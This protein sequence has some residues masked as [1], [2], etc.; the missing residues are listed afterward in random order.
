MTTEEDAPNTDISVE[1]MF[2]F[3]PNLP[4][5]RVNILASEYISI[6]SGKPFQ[7]LLLKQI[8]TEAFED[9]NGT[10][11]HIIYDTLEKTWSAEHD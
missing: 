6:L 7:G 11:V 1:I 8:L 5:M 9:E 3:E 10:T 4:W 2:R